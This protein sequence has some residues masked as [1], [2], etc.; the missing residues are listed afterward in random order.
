LLTVFIAPGVRAAPERVPVGGGQPRLAGNGTD[1]AGPP[2]RSRSVIAV[3]SLDRELVEGLAE[4]ASG[5]AP[6]STPDPAATAPQPERRKAPA[7]QPTPDAAPSTSRSP[8]T[9][10]RPRASE[11]PAPRAQLA[12]ANPAPI[13]VASVAVRVAPPVVAHPVTVV[14]P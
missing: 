2:S 13:T 11:Q 1:S 5:G 3:Q 10:P 9:A 4:D 7:P 6:V 12:P 14:A 8:S